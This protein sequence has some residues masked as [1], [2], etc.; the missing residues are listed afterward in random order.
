MSNDPQ[1]KAIVQALCVSASSHVPVW[2]VQANSRSNGACI[3]PILRMGYQTIAVCSLQEIASHVF[4]CQQ[5]EC[6]LLPI[7]YSLNYLMAPLQWR[8]FYITN[9]GHSCQ[10]KVV[11]L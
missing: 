3:E 4:V 2:Q 5:L 8:V 9:G 1:V 10:H 7:R 11:S 6:S